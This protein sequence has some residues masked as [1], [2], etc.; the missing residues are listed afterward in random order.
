[1]I[2]VA[3][4]SL[5]LLCFLLINLCCHAFFIASK[6]D[7]CRKSYTLLSSNSAS[8]GDDE[9]IVSGFIR[10]IHFPSCHN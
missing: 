2:A 6:K 4:T 9:A 8:L 7:F 1:M 3:K 10:H 5:F